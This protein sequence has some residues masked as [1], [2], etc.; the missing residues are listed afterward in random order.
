MVKLFFVFVSDTILREM[1]V[2][3]NTHTTLRRTITATIMSTYRAWVIEKP[4]S[5]TD[6]QVQS[7]PLPE[8]KPGTV[9]FFEKFQ[10]MMGSGSFSLPGARQDEGCVYES[11]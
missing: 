6:M 11:R 1:L 2:C 9:Q 4:G 10:K 7:L 8:P 3:R 5:Y